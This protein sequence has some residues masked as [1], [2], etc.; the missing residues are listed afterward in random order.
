MC[1]LKHISL[2]DRKLSSK[3]VLFSVIDCISINKKSLSIF[4][5]IVSED[6][7]LIANETWLGSFVGESVK[8]DLVPTGYDVIRRDRGNGRR[9]EG[10]ILIVKKR[11]DVVTVKKITRNFIQFE[12]LE[13]SDNDNKLRMKVCIIYR[14]SPSSTNGLIS[15]E[16][17]KNIISILMKIP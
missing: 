13:F 7:G 15:N 5:Y 9:S 12:Q 8:N 4:D 14:P 2:V 17:F 10:I 1:P 16:F 11:N 3:S 6:L